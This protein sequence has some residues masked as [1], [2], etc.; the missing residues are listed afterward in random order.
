M[1]IIRQHQRCWQLKLKKE[2][3]V[4]KGNGATNYRFEF[5]EEDYTYWKEQTLPVILIFDN[6]NDGKYYWVKF[7]EQFIKKQCA[8]TI[9]TKF[10]CQCLI[11]FQETK[12]M[13]R[14]KV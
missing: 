9:L 14:L 11:Y 2:P 5:S 7:D 1:K 4:L 13:K 6:E 3:P 10:K 12:H 8:I